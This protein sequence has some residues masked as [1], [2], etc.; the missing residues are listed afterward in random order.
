MR[1]L[2]EVSR[3]DLR[4]YVAEQHLA[5]REDSSN[6]DLGIPRNRVRHELLPYLERE[7]SPGVAAVFAREAVIARD[8]ED[9]LNTEAID[10]AASIVLTN[11]SSC[12]VDAAA[13]SRIHR[14]LASRVARL[15]LSR[16]AAGRFLG[17]EHVER[18][19]RFVAEGPPGAVVSLPG[20]RAVHRGATVVLGPE[21]PRRRPKELSNSFRVPLSIPGEVTLD[22]G[23]GWAISAEHL[24]AAEWAQT[25]WRARGP[26]VVVA[27]GPLSLPLAVR[28]RRAGDR[29]SP[30]GLGR[31]RKKL[32][33]FL[34]NRKVPREARDGLPLVVD[35]D[36]RIV[37][38]VGESVAED[39][40]VTDPS[41]GVIL[42]KVR[43][44]GGPG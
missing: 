44:L 17:Y 21:G 36:D 27:M 38:V 41:Q 8:D 3:A 19:L 32:Q 5:F 43:R 37:W 33:D 10:L 29:F 39:F 7:F 24:E 12:E 22:N 31:R 25:Y 23:D 40:R 18:F 34:V 30:L 15:T 9:R 4:R 35:G 6:N 11:E 28:S 20:Q 13:L 26:V 42:L 2:L 16:L 14:A 1:P